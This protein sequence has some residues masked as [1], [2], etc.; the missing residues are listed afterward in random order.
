MFAVL[1]NTNA[2]D[3]VINMNRLLWM[4]WS[5]FQLWYGIIISNK[6]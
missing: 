4:I 3:F 1:E 5:C 6:K 2:L